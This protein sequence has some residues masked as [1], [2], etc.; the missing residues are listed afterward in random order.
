M[1]T[2]KKQLQYYDYLLFIIR[3]SCQRTHGTLELCPSLFIQAVP[4]SQHA[5]FVSTDEG[6]IMTQ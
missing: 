4:S 5:S 6:H 2:K 3:A 1:T